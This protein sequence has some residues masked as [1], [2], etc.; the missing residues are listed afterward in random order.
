[1][2]KMLLS[3]LVPFGY[4]SILVSLVFKL[5]F[6]ITAGYLNIRIQDAAAASALIA[7]ATAIKVFDLSA[8]SSF[9]RVIIDQGKVHSAVAL[10]LRAFL[11]IYSVTIIV[12]ALI[13]VIFLLIG[14]TNPRS[15]FLDYDEAIP[16]ALL[17]AL[18][19]FVYWPVFTSR[20]S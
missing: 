20:L 16:N 18:S 5:L 4:F 2:T 6:K 3:R 17:P 8:A 10:T 15:F 13:V 7:L 11:V 12:Y 14:A 9:A 1:M 19:W